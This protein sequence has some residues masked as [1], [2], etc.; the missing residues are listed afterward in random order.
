MVNWGG[1]WEYSPDN[2]PTG[3]ELFG[4]GA[5]HT[6]FGNYANTQANQLIAA[7]HTAANA[8][9]ALNS[10]QNYMAKTLPVIY[11]PSAAY[12]ISAISKKLHGVTQNP[13]LDLAPE[14][15]YFTK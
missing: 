12:S 10:Y 15:W 8:Q 11:Q 3:G 6:G 7:T 2:Y 13:F 9:A 14:T 1:G 5:G 4:S